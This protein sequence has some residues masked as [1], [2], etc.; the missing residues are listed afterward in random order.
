MRD[1]RLVQSSKRERPRGKFFLGF[2][3]VKL[4]RLDSKSRVIDCWQV[5][6][7]YSIY[8]ERHKKVRNT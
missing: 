4:R 8:G 3:V 7:L 6:L 2:E 5:H 1:V